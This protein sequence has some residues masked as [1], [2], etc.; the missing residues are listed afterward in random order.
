MSNGKGRGRKVGSAGKPKTDSDTDIYGYEE[1]RK[2]QEQ[3]EREQRTSDALGL[4][5]EVSEY[6]NRYSTRRTFANRAS[7]ARKE[8]E[9]TNKQLAAIL[10]VSDRTF[11]R[12]MSG[13]SLPKLEDLGDLCW[14]LHVSPNYL[15]GWNEKLDERVWMATTGN[16]FSDDR[17]Y[18]GINQHP[19]TYKKRRL[20]EKAIY[21]M[22]DKI[23]EIETDSDT[24][25][26]EADGS[27]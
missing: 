16:W 3:L 8:L 15:L 2:P 22:L 6:G 12:W 23:K 17:T 14:V 25:S 26:K 13:E 4:N 20:M 9:M 11:G 10:H 18:I 21:K 1:F 5:V 24:E 27:D 19:L 7:E